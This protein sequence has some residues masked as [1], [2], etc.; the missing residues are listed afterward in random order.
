METEQRQATVVRSREK[1]IG[2]ISAVADEPVDS[3]YGVVCP[4]SA[5]F[6]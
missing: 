1:G 2:I 4:M 3:V 5:S 6:A